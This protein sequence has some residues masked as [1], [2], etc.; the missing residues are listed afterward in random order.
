M[1]SSKYSGLPRRSQRRD[2]TEMIAW[3][4]S[5]LQRVEVLA[6]ELV[7]G[8]TPRPEAQ[9]QAAERVRSERKARRAA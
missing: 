1:T 6:R 5:D 7:A 8:G 4:D 3:S 9:R 2:F